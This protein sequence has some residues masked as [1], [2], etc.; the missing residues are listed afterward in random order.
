MSDIQPATAAV[1]HAVSGVHQTRQP[2]AVAGQIPVASL[3]PTHVGA[4][5][6]W[7]NF[8]RMDNLR[9]RPAYAANLWFAACQ[10]ACSERRSGGLTSRSTR[11]ANK[12]GG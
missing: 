9:F 4:L 7:G 5:Q 12:R 1:V 2:S 11:D 10:H 6:V 8:L 3:L